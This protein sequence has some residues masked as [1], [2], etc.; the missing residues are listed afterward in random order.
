MGT[1]SVNYLGVVALLVEAV[2]DLQQ[3]VDELQLKLE[4]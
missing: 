3:Q 4:N 2:K 1:K